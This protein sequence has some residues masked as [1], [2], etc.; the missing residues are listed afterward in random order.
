VYA[1]N[2]EPVTSRM[3]AALGEMASSSLGGALRVAEVA[4]LADSARQA[5][6]DGLGVAT[7]IGACV[8]GTGAVL[9]NRFLPSTHHVSDEAEILAEDAA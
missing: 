4:G 7:I 8:A 1:S 5:F 6:V 9:A 3:P 2:L